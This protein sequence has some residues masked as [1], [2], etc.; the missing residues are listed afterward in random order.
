M[1]A[2]AAPIPR[3]VLLRLADAIGE[4]MVIGSFARDHWVHDVAQLPKGAQT[5]D[6]DVTIA[7]ATFDEY[8][9]RLARLSGPTGI[10]IVYEVAGWQVDIIPYGPVGPNGIIEPVEGVTLDVTGLADAAASATTWQIGDAQVKVPTLA[11]LTGL[12]IIAWD[13]RERQ[14]LKDARDLVGLLAATHSGPFEDALWRDEPSCQRWD[15]DPLMVG[16]YRAGREVAR[17][18]APVSVERLAR[19]L[20]V[21][22]QRDLT[23]AMV[24]TTGTAAAEA[25]DQLAAFRHGLDDDTATT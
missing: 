13:Y 4:F 18:W 7:V 10:G 19:A 14:T 12:K 2:A 20:T 23:A 24:R 11:S 1:T 25:L 5:I 22:R 17:S 16:P 9:Q 21:E 3:E 6:L 15:Y 8:H